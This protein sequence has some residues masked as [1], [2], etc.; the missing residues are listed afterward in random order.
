MA[1][2]ADA[3]MR[4]DTTLRVVTAEVDFLPER[5]EDWE[6]ESDDNRIG[7]YLEWKEFMDRL[8]DV[9]DLYRRGQLT[10]DQHRRYQE[11]LED[12]SQSLPIIRRL[13]L[14]L[15]SMLLKN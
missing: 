11:L 13:E 14:V 2:N 8:D 9:S 1:T 10:S 15:P 5:A 3:I 6:Q 12:L 7:F 4:V